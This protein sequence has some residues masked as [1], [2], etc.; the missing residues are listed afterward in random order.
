M[1]FF[2]AFL[3]G[4][5]PS[6]FIRLF[7]ALL[8]LAGG[9]AL[10]EF[11]TTQ[12]YPGVTYSHEERSEP[13]MRIFAVTV[14]LRG[15]SAQVAPSGPDPDGDGKWQTVLDETAD[16]AQ[17]EQF[18][19]AVN[20]DF[21]SVAEVIDPQTEKKRGYHEGQSSLVI[22]PA[23]TDGRQWARS[24]KPRPCLIVLRDG[25]AMIGEPK[26]LPGTARQAIAGSHIILKDGKVPA[27]PDSGFTKTRHPR[28]AVGVADGGRK[29][30]LAV[31]D[32]RRPG[33]SVGM[34]LAELADLMLQLGC[35][36]A[37][38]L[39][40]GGSSTLVMRNPETDELVVMNRPSDGKQRP[41]AN[42]LGIKLDAAPST[43]PARPN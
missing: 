21:F 27:L 6:R 10:A 13:A 37:L 9:I 40:G 25:R 43:R 26:Q 31:V 29:L 18:D 42:V 14:E 4:I 24:E 3:R 1:L 17:R 30:V 34:S 35:T 16:V 23:M 39:D 36:D 19:I 2:A 41:V 12:P 33:V 8:A 15:A 38:N 11:P 28:T 20:G 5:A 22:G 32:G 7:T